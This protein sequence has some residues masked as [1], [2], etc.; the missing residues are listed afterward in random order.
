[1]RRTGKFRRNVVETD[2]FGKQ[3]IDEQR[4][5]VLALVKS[6]NSRSNMFSYFTTQID[7]SLRIISGEII[8]AQPE[9]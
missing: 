5:N 1:V 8:I 3:N 4:D 9:I 6:N 7:I 2:N